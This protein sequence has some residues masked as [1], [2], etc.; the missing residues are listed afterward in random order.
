MHPDR[1]FGEPLVTSCGYTARALF[2]SYHAEGGVAAAAEAYGVTREEVEL[3][4]S[5]FDHLQ[6]NSAA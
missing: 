2:E 6:G 1:R 4:C 3:A 5:Y